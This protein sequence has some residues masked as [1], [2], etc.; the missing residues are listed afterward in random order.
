M[1]PAI[2]LA[3]SLIHR[4][5]EDWIDQHRPR[6]NSAPHE[7]ASW[8]LQYRNCVPETLTY[9]Q[10]FILLFR[11]AKCID[12]LENAGVGPPEELW[13]DLL[14]DNPRRVKS[15]LHEIRIAT[16]YQLAG[17]SVKIIPEGPARTPD[18]LVG[19]EVEVEC[20]H[21]MGA[22]DGDK[23]R[24]EMYDLLDRKLRKIFTDTADC[25]ALVVSVH[26]HI[27]PVRAMLD[28]I[29]DSARSLVRG[30]DS[31]IEKN[32]L[33]FDYSI[34]CIPSQDVD[35]ASMLSVPLQKS[36]VET[37]FLRE[38]SSGV[39]VSLEDG[40]QGIGRRIFLSISCDIE[41]DFIKSVKYSLK[42]AVGQFS[43]RFPAIIVIDVTD[44]M[45]MLH[46]PYFKQMES[47]IASFLRSN[48]TV[49]R[50]DLEFNWFEAEERGAVLKRR[51][52]FFD[53]KDAKKPLPARYA[54]HML[55]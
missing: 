39:V 30:A 52:M 14:S 32:S 13:R 7:I 51:F 20:K 3:E 22:S 42:D 19:G 43:G 8:I 26:F 44:V 55:N 40:T 23:S 25:G 9:S 34:E 48:T 27:E 54:P 15:A 38:S 49:S 18:L 29:V 46:E 33:E 35:S 45:G 31:V 6:S 5:G 21:K 37:P 11:L 28:E 17:F 53:N 1:D 4:I 2:A 10:P 41:H 12:I 36:D 47:L 16:T 50:I 24:Y